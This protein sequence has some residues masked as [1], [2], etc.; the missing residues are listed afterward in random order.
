MLT[1]ESLPHTIGV[2]GDLE[3]CGN[4]GVDKRSEIRVRVTSRLAMDYSSLPSSLVFFESAI[5]RCSC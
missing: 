2:A 5:F 1:F 3:T 4:L